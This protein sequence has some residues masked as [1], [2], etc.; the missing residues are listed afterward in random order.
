MKTPKILKITDHNYP[1]LLKQIYN[2]PKL[3]FYKGNIEILKKTCISIVGTRK[4]SDYGKFIT[5]KIVE[6]LSELDI[7]IV[8]GLAI[9]IDTIAHKSALKNSLPTIAILGSGINN[10]YPKENHSFAQELI[11]NNLLLSEFPDQDEPNK[12]TFPQRNRIVSGLSVATIIIEAPERSGALITAKLALD[13]GREIFVTPGDIDRE[14]SLGVL[15]LLQRGGA[16]PISSGED[17]I[18]VLKTQPYLFDYDDCI[19][20]ENSSPSPSPSPPPQTLL[21]PEALYKLTKEQETLL[22]TIPP[23]RHSSLD[24]IHKK[25]SLTTSEI[26]SILSILEIKGIITTSCGKYLRK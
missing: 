6:E 26:L 4:Y 9:G 11:K 21:K 14:N 1:T 17:I 13:Q 19:K 25:T 10:I 24:D 7:A 12:T 16:Y 2:S 20:K 23:R 18:Q 3:L 15:R 5:E 8:S 22:K